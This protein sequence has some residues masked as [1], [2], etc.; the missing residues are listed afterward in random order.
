M[1]KKAKILVVEDERIVAEDIEKNLMKLGYHVTALASSGDQAIKAARSNRPDL[2][3]M[4][5]VL[6][7]RKTGI[8]TAQE[9]RSELDVPVVYLTAYADEN[10]LS[11]AKITEPSGYLL[12]PFEKRELHSVIEMALYKHSTEHQLK[13]TKRGLQPYF[14]VLPTEL[15]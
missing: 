6:Q 8:E 11:K 12:K 5:I 4:D 7:G 10:T 13:K 2:V 9:L 1:G 3:L 14:K 15:L